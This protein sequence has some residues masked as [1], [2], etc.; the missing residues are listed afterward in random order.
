MHI[1]IAVW[2][3]ILCVE[4]PLW[5]D[6]HGQAGGEHNGRRG[7]VERVVSAVEQVYIDA[8]RLGRLAQIV[9]QTDKHLDVQLYGETHEARGLAAVAVE[10]I[11]GE[12][13]RMKDKLEVAGRALVVVERALPEHVAH[14]RRHVLLLLVGEQVAARSVQIS[15]QFIVDIVV[16]LDRAECIRTAFVLDGGRVEQSDGEIG[17]ERVPVAH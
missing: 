12:Q 10:A 13:Q 6:V 1:A 16:G 3:R 14:Q 4:L 11:A 5:H 2:R 15:L 7:V 17:R 9:G 8:S